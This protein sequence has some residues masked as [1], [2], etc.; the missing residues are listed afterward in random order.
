MTL[1]MAG[2]FNRARLLLTESVELAR[3]QRDPFNGV[4]Y[5]LGFA[6]L[7]A[8]QGQPERAVRIAG[9]VDALVTHSALIAP[10]TLNRY[11]QK[12]LTQAR[13]ALGSRA[14]QVWESGQRMSLEEATAY[15]STSEQM[16]AESNPLSARER[17]VAVLLACGL[18]NREIAQQLVVS[19]RTAEAHVAH[20]LT[21]LGLSTRLQ[22]ALWASEHETG[23]GGNTD[24]GGEGRS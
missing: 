8:A 6:Q 15:A 24:A 10:D 5:L 13:A 12:W 11:V 3:G 18:S 16:S 22:I 1:I 20:I 23:I 2:D 7:A 19:E 4:R 14:S 9:A 17:E 21:K